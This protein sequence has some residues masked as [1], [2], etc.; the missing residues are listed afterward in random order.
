MHT[1]LIN[2]LQG[3]I[4]KERCKY[5][6]KCDCMHRLKEKNKKKNK[7]LSHRIQ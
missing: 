2:R 3:L 6:N 1:I 5:K 4:S 7:D